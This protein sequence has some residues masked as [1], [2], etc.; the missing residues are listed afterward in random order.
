MQTFVHT[1]GPAVV[2]VLVNT[3]P[4]IL[5]IISGVLVAIGTTMLSLLKPRVMAQVAVALW[6]LKLPV[7]VTVAIVWGGMEAWKHVSAAPTGEVTA[8]ETEA[9]DWPIF[10]RDESRRGWVGDGPGPNAGGVNWAFRRDIH[11]FFSSP[12]VVGN[13]VYI[14]SAR[15]GAFNRIGR[16]FCF[17]ADTGGLVWEGGP[18]DMRP[19]FSSPVVYGNR[20]VIGEGLHDTKDARIIVISL[21]EENLG[22]VIWT[23]ATQSHVECTPVVVDG[24]IY[25]S[26]GDDGIYCFELEPDEEGNPRK[27]WHLPGEDYVDAETSLIVHE[28]I[29]YAGLGYGGDAMCIIDAQTGTE[30]KRIKT[31]Y[32]V[33]G[34]P[35]VFGDQV[36]FGMGNG[37]YVF[38]AQEKGLPPGG[39]VWSID[40]STHEVLW[41]FPLPETVLGSVAVTEDRIFIAC[42]DGVLYVLD[43]RGR[44]VGSW[45]SHGKM[46]ASPAVCSERVYV[47]TTS[48][49]VYGLNKRTLELEWQIAASSGDLC[50][51]SPAVARGRLFVGTHLDGMLS[52]GRVE[53]TTPMPLWPGSQG[54]MATGGN[55]SDG[56]LPA[57]G[58]YHWSFPP[59]QMGGDERVTVSGAVAAMEDR[60]LVPIK[61]GNLAG[62]VRIGHGGGGSAAEPDWTWPREEGVHRTPAIA[63]DRVFVATGAAGD[64][65]RILAALDWTDGRTLWNHYIRMSA[66]GMVHATTEHLY[67]TTGGNELSC[68]DH[69]GALVWQANVGNIVWEPVFRDQMMV[70]AD[71]ERNALV[72]LDRSTGA[73]LWKREI[74][75]PMRGPPV[76]LGSVHS[77]VLYLPTAGGLEARSPVDGRLDPGMPPSPAGAST[78]P[79]LWQ[80]QMVYVDD[81]GRLLLRDVETGRITAWTA[82]ALPG[83]APMPARDRILFAS[84]D[85]LMSWEPSPREHPETELDEHGL[86]RTGADDPQPEEWVDTSWLGRFTAPMVWSE[87]RI[88]VGMAGWG[89]TRL[90]A[91]E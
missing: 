27:V 10:R 23:Y 61:T 5:A 21:D 19:T 89:L 4:I 30:L 16:V 62:L 72:A 17:D 74:E 32:P 26:A 12:T 41:K 2:P 55:P 57:L 51:S 6:R 79:V 18:R 87:G 36:I 22:E 77:P 54:G 14:V 65:A 37:D 45:N 34:P 71:V 85:G 81:M 63:G 46:A 84:A 64:E 59:D 76:F 82:G 43:H 7:L 75:Q 52:L 73:R 20:L 60:L 44:R 24:R 11:S 48:G 50:I 69:D 38:T 42:T 90:G 28:G 15:M 70:V 67:A 88:Y 9:G 3:L 83:V 68:F 40:S 86:P 91:S 35:A 56:P 1:S 39:A 78:T 25:V 47:F 29:V 66:S 31:P 8:A 53:V 58:A 80:G 33:F 13:R 49:M